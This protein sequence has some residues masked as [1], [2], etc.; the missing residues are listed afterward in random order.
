RQK[1]SV[2]IVFLELLKVVSWFN[3]FIYLLQN[4]LKTVHE[5]IADEQTAA[6]ETDALTYSSF[7]VNNA[8][9][10]GGSSI[11]HSFFNYNLLKKRIVMLN[12]KRSGNLARLKYLIAV[13]VCAGLLC[14]STLAFSKTYGWVDIDPAKAVKLEVIKSTLQTPVKPTAFKFPP[15]SVY[16]KGYGRLMGHIQ[17]NVHYTDAV[18]DEKNSFVGISL[19][20][21]ADHKIADVSIFKSADN[22]YDAIAKE[23]FAGFDGVV[24]A[25]PGKHTFMLNFFSEKGYN[26]EKNLDG[27]K[28][29]VNLVI[30]RPKPGEDQVKF[31]PPIVKRDQVKFPPPIVKPDAKASNEKVDTISKADFTAF[32]KDLANK[33]RYPAADRDKGIVGRAVLQFYVDKDKTIQYIKV[34]RSPSDNLSQEIIRV[35]KSS[36]YLK[37]FKG[38]T[39]SLPVAFTMNGGFEATQ[40]GS[41]IVYN[42]NGFNIPAMVQPTGYLNEVVI[43]SY[44]SKPVTPVQ[45]ADAIEK[46]DLEKLGLYF[47]RNIKYPAADRQETIGGRVITLFSVDADHNLQ[48]AKV[49]RTP[50]A[51]M[52]DEV[53]RV[54]KKCTDF[55]PLKPGVQYTLRVAFT[56]GYEDSSTGIEIEPKYRGGTESPKIYN[57]NAVAIPFG[58]GLVLNDVVIR[59]YIKKQAT[60]GKT[61]GDATKPDFTEFKRYFVNAISYPLEAK[62]QGVGGVV[63]TLFSVD[64]SYKVAYIRIT[65]SP[66]ERLS[67][68]V[69]NALKAMPAMATLKPGAIYVLPV[70]FFRPDGSVFK[71]R[72][73]ANGS[74][75][76]YK[77]GSAIASTDDLIAINLA[78]INAFG[79]GY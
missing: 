37:A 55:D 73:L 70:N 75:L 36:P 42:P 26:N 74:E 67:N 45:T 68:E 54:L 41:A 72:T 16:K 71:P 31:P 49:V 39:W 11:T 21:R 3:P 66:A 15:P 46:P 8:Y 56:L 47:S 44:T 28:Y 65:K 20:V 48:Y 76:T 51:A 19:N 40:G 35:L 17:H 30:V 79:P 59:G 2:D 23:A 38:G 13:P 77:S 4:S 12:Q 61:S 64:N 43:R 50:S 32:Y 5:Y 25:N 29:D 22:G 7:L 53:I 24:L 78:P 52:G 33:I 63:F 9:G 6:Y 69:I 58:G 62:Q 18:K 27:S 14:A 1:H 10:A 34:I 60:P 57:P